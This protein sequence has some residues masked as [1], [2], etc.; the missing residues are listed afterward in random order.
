MSYCQNK[1][2]GKHYNG[3]II[4]PND[5]GLR[6]TTDYI[7]ENT[8]V[9]EL[10]MQIIERVVLCKIDELITAEMIGLPLSPYFFTMKIYEAN[11]IEAT[12]IKK[13]WRLGRGASSKEQDIYDIIGACHQGKLLDKQPMM[14]T[15]IDEIC[16]DELKRRSY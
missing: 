12:I 15:R 8:E 2:A 16:N 3:F 7:L 4:P 13:A 14:Y 9:S 10:G 11:F 5:V 6:I 1:A